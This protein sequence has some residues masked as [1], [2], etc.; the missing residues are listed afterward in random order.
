LIEVRA[1]LED[2]EGELRGALDQAIEGI[3]R[4]SKRIDEL[5]EGD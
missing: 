4:L 3:Q 5:L 1:G 2:I